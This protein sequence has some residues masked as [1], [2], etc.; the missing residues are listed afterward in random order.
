MMR[1]WLTACVCFLV[2]LALLFI[3]MQPVYLSLA[4]TIEN[5][6]HDYW[7]DYSRQMWMATKFCGVLIAWAAIL[8]PFAGEE[9]AVSA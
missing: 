1:L 9:D 2:P 5:P 3:A 8:F 7:I 4:G 6:D